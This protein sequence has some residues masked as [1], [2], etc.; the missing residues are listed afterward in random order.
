MPQA[1]RRPSVAPSSTESEAN[2]QRGYLGEPRQGA[3]TRRSVGSR[4]RSPSAAQGIDRRHA[5][6][7][8]GVWT[9]QSV[10]RPSAGQKLSVESMASVR[11]D[12]SPGSNRGLNARRFEERSVL[13]FTPMR[14]KR[15]LAWDTAWGY[16][17]FNNCVLLKDCAWKLELYIIE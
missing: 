14:P 12:R 7:T 10:F 1:M 2:R 17:V 5:G 8:M 11:R 16:W 4:G 9:E 6:S 13:G 15:G 3:K